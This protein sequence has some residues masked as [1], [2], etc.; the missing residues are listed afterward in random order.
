MAERVKN[1]LAFR[2]R[3][4]STLLLHGVPILL[5]LFL[6]TTVA[7]AQQWPAYGNDAGGTRY[8]PLTQISS[9]NVS[10]LKPAWTYHMGEL[11]RDEVEANRHHTAPFEATPIVV[12]GVLYFSTPSNRVIA[13][14]S[15][16][17]KELWQFDPQA[18][19][20]GRHH[21]FQHRGV[22]YWQSARGKEARIVYGTFDGRLI[23]LNAK[24]GKRCADFGTNGE[25]D[26]R[27]GAQA[28]P[29]VGDMK[30]EY[31][32]TSPVAIY[33]DL[34]IVGAAVPEFPRKGPSGMVRAFD[35]RSGKLVWTFHTIPQPGELQ[36]ESWS[37]DSWKDRTGANV[38]SI[39]SVD[40]KRGL[41]FL[42]VGSSSYDFYGADRPGN[43]LFSN[44]LVALDA[45]TGKLVW[46]YQMVH[47]DVWDYDLPAQP[48]LLNIHRGQ[49]EIPA[50][51]QV[52]KMGY[53]FVLDRETGKPLFP[54]EER[55]FPKSTVPGEMAS[56]TQ[57]VPLKPP[58][59]ARQSAAASEITDVTP[60]SNSYCSEFFKT[61]EHR[62]MYGPYNLS[63]TLV[64]P[65]SLGGA[66][67]SGATFDP[68]SGYLFVNVNEL[69]AV[70]AMQPQPPGSA[71]PY[72]RGSKEGEYARFW[73]T[74]HLPCQQ[75]PWG[76]LNAVD[77]NKG[78]IVWKVPLGF[79]EELKT[80]TGTPNLGGSI[81]ANGLV[82]IGAT[83]DNRF[84]AFDAKDGTELWSYTLKANAH[85][86]PLT[87]LGKKSKRQF[88]VIAAGG[89]G[90]LGIKVS[91]EVIAFAL[92][93]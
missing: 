39:M 53:V 74:H 42:P 36:H 8:S 34:A 87:Y 14:D 35:V 70:G 11:D 1:T 63:Q 93:E 41:V 89:G 40:E 80:K 10:T 83:M 7:T 15:E 55:E 38:W 30:M 66:N 56:P 78:E 28:P 46:F 20:A 26:L 21:F 37:G 49:K 23:A 79:F 19:V 51:V 85:A 2:L 77:I 25:V 58:P 27:P 72:R 54:V 60:E 92:P 13:L 33:K 76:T 50:V 84:R 67:W 47:H 22:S 64:F 3:I 82:F 32:V 43:N 24:D 59:L 62:G 17:G 61:L 29:F 91:D 57:P 48:V 86:A 18:S 44:S 69:G 75:P 71:E 65:G 45:A 6:A 88:V 12:D 4:S 52:T 5:G 9:K 16:T 73:D 81:V 31:S 68:T 90:S